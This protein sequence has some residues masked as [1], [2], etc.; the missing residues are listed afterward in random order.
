VTRPD[1]GL[2]IAFIDYFNIQLVI[3]NNI[4]LSLIY[5]LYS[6]PLH[7]HTH[8]HTL[9]FSVFN[10]R[11][12]ATDFNTVIITRKVFSSPADFQIPTELVI[13]SSQSSS[14]AVSRDSLSYLRLPILN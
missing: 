12:L 6:S 1:F 14:N 13:I 2:E 10:S 4:A 9:G 11:I 7:T 5:T 3:T 8:T